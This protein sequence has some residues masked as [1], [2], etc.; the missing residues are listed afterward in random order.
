MSKP[1]RG[2]VASLGVLAVLTAAC[3][4]PDATGEGRMSAPADLVIAGGRV[5]DPETELDA[6]RHVGVADGRIVAVSESPLEGR[7]TIDAT[8]LVVAPGFIDL[9]AH[10]QDSVSAALQARD[11]V[12]TALE[13]EIGVY[14]VAEWIASREGRAIINYGA[15]V[16]H[17]GARLKLLTGIDVGHATTAPPGERSEFGSDVIYES[18]DDDQILELNGLIAQGLEE[19][20][21][22]IGFGIT[23]T[24]GASRTEIYRAF[25]L[26]AAQGAP[27][28][29]HLR[30]ADSGGTLGAFQEVIANALAT[31]AALHI[32]HMN[33]TSGEMA[34]TTLELIRGAR[35]GGID[36]TTESYPYT[37]SST[38]IESAIFDTW[39]D[40]TDEEYATLQW[41][42]TPERL[43][44]ESFRRYQAQGGWVVMHGRN[45]ETNEWIVAQ[46]DVMVAS[47]G[48]P[49]LYEAVHPRGAGTFA[50]VLGHYVRERGA[51]TLMEALAKMTLQPA[52]R[53]TGFAP[54]MA[55]KGRV[56]VGTDADLTLFDPTTIIDRATYAEPAAPSEGILHVLVDGTLVVRDGSV[57][58]GVYPGRAIRSGE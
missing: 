6:I 40:R 36:I 46:P 43:N 22:G 48:I 34:R 37:A 45:E 35:D 33:S 47:D 41:S 8:G 29:V 58:P 38:R 12:T 15:T 57:V 13:M 51:L 14:P 20:G 10:G 2:S 26:A 53:L 50:R 25:Q 44:R 28:Y 49:Y 39:D 52:N 16:S 27:A 42:G 56:Q 31:G 23:Y 4:A 5:M 54:G 1:K 19:G 7:D 24:P 21:L 32:V 9:H 11:G 55:R 3:A 17:P 30:G 18:L